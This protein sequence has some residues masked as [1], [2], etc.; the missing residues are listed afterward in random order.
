MSLIDH[1]W[2][3]VEVATEGHFEGES[4]QGFDEHGFSLVS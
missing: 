2:G 1:R 4:K 3:K